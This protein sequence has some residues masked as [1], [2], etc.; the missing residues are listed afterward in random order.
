MP[1][2]ALVLLGFLLAADLAVF[3]GLWLMAVRSRAN[4]PGAVGR[5]ALA[6]GTG[7][8][9]YV[10]SSDREPA[11][12]VEPLRFRGAPAE[13][14]RAAVAAVQ[15]LEKTTLVVLEDNYLHA[16]VR[17]AFFGFVDDLELKLHPDEKV[18]HARSASRTGHW[19]AGAN[20]RRVERVRETFEKQLAS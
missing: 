1:T 17:S 9:N 14:W 3:G 8:P 16:E 19:D 13:A 5:G 4:P 15:S 20:R 11:R 6:R 2:I 10:A 12:R 7:K 18:I